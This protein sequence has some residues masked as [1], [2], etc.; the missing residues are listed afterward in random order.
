MQTIRWQLIPTLRLQLR[1]R[2]RWSTRPSA[3][4]SSSENG[5]RTRRGTND[6]LS[7][8]LKPS[9]CPAQLIVISEINKVPFR[10]KEGVNRKILIELFSVG[11]SYKWFVEMYKTLVSFDGSPF[12]RFF[13]S[14]FFPL[15]RCMGMFCK[16]FSQNGEP[17][18]WN[19]AED[20]CCFY[21]FFLPKTPSICIFLSSFFWHIF[22]PVSLLWYCERRDRSSRG[23]L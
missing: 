22:A 17:F 19:F 9:K 3:A 5:R 21:F 4:A 11:T 20:D 18:L 7:T 13:V 15:P 14:F 6:P 8:S 2:W 10:V 16:S 23:V 12:F 1:Q